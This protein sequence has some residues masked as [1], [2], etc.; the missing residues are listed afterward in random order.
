MVNLDRCIKQ[1]EEKAI[2]LPFLPLALMCK[3]NC[4]SL[5]I[6]NVCKFDNKNLKVDMR[7]S[8]F[9]T[10]FYQNNSRYKD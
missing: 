1:Q 7:T 8:L 9:D 6:K 2:S 10:L 4:L 5:Q 3:L